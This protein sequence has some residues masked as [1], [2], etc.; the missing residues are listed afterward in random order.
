MQDTAQWAWLG[1]VALAHG[2]IVMLE[3]CYSLNLLG[4]A[5]IGEVT[6][7]LH[8]AQ[9]TFT[10]P[11]LAL[12]LAI[13]SALV[14]YHGL[15]RRRVAQTLGQ[16]LA[17]LAMMLAGLWAI[18]DPAGSVGALTVWVNESSVGALAAVAAGTPSHPDQTLGSELKSVF[19]DVVSGPWCYLEFG[20][21]RWC[22]DPRLLDPRVREA[23]LAIAREERSLAGG[24]YASGPEH[25]ALLSSATL[26]ARANDNGELFLALPANGAARNSINESRSLLSVL[27]GGAHEATHCDGPTAAEA[28]FRTQHGTWPRVVGLLLVWIGALAALALFGWIGLRLLAAAILSLLLLLIAPAAVLAPALGDGGRELFRRWGTR[29]VGAIVAKLLYSVLLGAALLM[30]NLLAALPALGWWTQW[31]LIAAGWWLAF[32]ER[33]ELL[34]L[35][36]VGDTMP[37][38]RRE[39]SRRMLST[40]RER[41]MRRAA[42]GLIATPGRWGRRVLSPPPRSEGRHPR[43]RP[44][45]GARARGLADKQVLATLDRD[46]RDARVRVEGAPAAQAAISE[47]RAQLRRVELARQ[48]IEERLERESDREA[49]TASAASRRLVQL[50]SRAQRLE[51]QIGREQVALVSARK[52]VAEGQRADGRAAGNFSEERVRQRARFY[53][54]QSAL[55]EKGRRDPAG[56]R[57]DYRALAPL[58]GRSEGEWDELGAEQR[59]RATL[60]IDDALA[61]RARVR[62]DEPDGSGTAGNLSD[63]DGG[64]R[65][66]RLARAPFSAPSRIRRS[67]SRPASP[68]SDWL[69]E[70]RK[71]GAAGRPPRT[72]AERARAEPSNPIAEEHARA[73]EQLRRLRRQFDRRGRGEDDD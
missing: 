11:G 49:P 54:E 10:T 24:R 26:I 65:R 52:L 36:R 3:W 34:S 16:V 17:M 69:E 45:G 47:K 53:D 25:R 48:K 32:H 27:C 22:R 12:V 42:D 60:A 56:R 1:L 19:G 59:R 40:M 64:S 44:E 33:H 5:L 13:A 63:R 21:V 14:V 62:R 6:S 66:E 46:L 68:L 55:P 37:L 2:L 67:R 15:I 41:T 72:L 71:A 20:N 43:P 28:E 30:T 18:A 58:A 70:E 31:L 50:D 29:L 9:A 73:Q 61:S 38:A 35:V 57:R 8:G 4:G 23:A 51:A 39:R 7:A